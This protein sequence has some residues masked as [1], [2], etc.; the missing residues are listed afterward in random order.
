[1]VTAVLPSTV[2][3]CGTPYRLTAS[4][5]ATVCVSETSENISDD[6]NTTADMN[7]RHINDINNNNN[8]RLHGSGSTVVTMTSKVIINS[9]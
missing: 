4:G 3:L 9:F 7:L 1:M 8:H 5:H 2:L 6:I